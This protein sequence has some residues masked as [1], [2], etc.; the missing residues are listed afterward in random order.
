MTL[1]AKNEK[2]FTNEY[3]N[4][5]QGLQDILE[6]YKTELKELTKQLDQSDARN[7]QLEQEIDDIRRDFSDTKSF[8]NERIE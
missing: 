5:I 2:D 8:Q 4:K 3:R 1:I 7:K 6:Q